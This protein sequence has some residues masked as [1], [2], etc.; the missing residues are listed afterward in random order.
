MDSQTYSRRRNA[1]ISAQMPFRVIEPQDLISTGENTYLIN[2]LELS[3]EPEVCEQLDA[4]I[5]VSKQQS[6]AVADTFGNNGIRDLRNYLALSNSIEK[7]GKIALIADPAQRK[8][9][10]ATPLKK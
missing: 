5:G 3:V 2:G 6:K 8:I 1:F 7:A 9:V 10:G 4:F